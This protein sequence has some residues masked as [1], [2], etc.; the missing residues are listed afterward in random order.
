MYFLGFVSFFKN[1]FFNLSVDSKFEVVILS[2]IDNMISTLQTAGTK[3]EEKIEAIKKIAS[4]KNI[5]ALDSL[6]GLLDDANTEVRSAAIWAIGKYK[7]SDKIT[8]LIP[9][10][11]DPEESVRTV[12]LKTLAKFT[13]NP[14][15]LGAILKL[16]EDNDPKVR[17]MVL[18]TIVEFEGP[19]TI[20]TI[21]DRLGK[22]TDKEVKLKAV[23]LLG[24][25]ISKDAK[26]SKALIAA[27]EEATEFDVQM[28]IVDQ[29]A[30]IDPY[31]KEFVMLSLKGRKKI[32]IESEDVVSKE[33][34]IDLTYRRNSPLV[35]KV[36][37]FK[38]EV[39]SIKRYI[40]FLDEKKQLITTS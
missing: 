11:K 34:S 17:K 30:K 16:L 22:E 9:K 2:S 5:R 7:S 39:E 6:V 38:E 10:I 27:L 26:A 18:E 37:G 29:L 36:R 25:F 20:E 4:S 24:G 23:E 35:M 8:M 15:I 32:F 3:P 31:I 13:S 1:A 14:E 12:A 19:N 28:A 21:I 33:A 40:A